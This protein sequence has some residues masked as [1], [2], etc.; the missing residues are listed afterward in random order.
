MSSIRERQAEQTSL[1]GRSR[2]ERL[3]DGI[4]QRQKKY[5]LQQRRRAAAEAASRIVLPD[6]KR[7]RLVLPETPSP[8]TDAAS[9]QKGKAKLRARASQ[10]DAATPSASGPKSVED[11]VATLQR[12]MWKRAKFPKAVKLLQQLWQSH[13]SSSTKR[14]LFAGFLTAASTE[15]CVNASE[16]RT[17]IQTFFRETIEPLLQSERRKRQDLALH[18]DRVRAARTKARQAVLQAQLATVVMPRDSAGGKRHHNGSREDR[19][20]GKQATVAAVAQAAAALVVG[21]EDAKR[22]LEGQ[23][24]QAP[25]GDPR[26]GV[27]STQGD[28]GDAVKAEA[29][30]EV[31][32][33]DEE[34][35]LLEILQ[36]RCKT[37][38]LLFTDDPFQF[39]QQV[40][41]LRRTVDAIAESV[42]AA[43][44]EGEEPEEDEEG[45]DDP[46]P[47]AGRQN[48]PVGADS[49]P[50]PGGPGA[51]FVEAS[52]SLPGDS[53]VS[54]SPVSPA[55]ATDSSHSGLREE[56]ERRGK[57]ACQ[58][59]ASGA[60]GSHTEVSSPKSSA[61][62]GQARET[63]DD[64]PD[65]RAEQQRMP[66]S[67]SEQEEEKGENEMPTPSD[68]ETP[69]CAGEDPDSEDLD[70]EMF[71]SPEVKWPLPL[72]K[73][74]LLNL[75]RCFF[76][77]CLATVFTYRNLSWARASIE[78]L[79][80]H[81]YLH[82][83]I[84]TESDQGQISLWQAQLKVAHKTATNITALGIGEAAHPVQDGRDER[85]STV[86]GSIVWSAKQMGC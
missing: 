82:R 76:I 6:E 28:R 77:D 19:D 70:E 74:E 35:E 47:E 51:K 23:K 52:A 8:S 32:L 26:D 33:S 62:P 9:A 16:G 37:H 20:S 65:N 69:D 73:S 48:S 39:N 14:C 68:P 75:M 10:H 22:R 2:A 1:L 50:L 66:A 12:H 30:D 36:L 86:H 83:S 54:S 13:F 3:L 72:K 71:E 11:A 42:E 44:A 79:F 81:V 18:L 60:T 31:E 17:E 43:A 85:I 55:K 29:Q 34:K 15:T 84:F 67:S 61:T 46:A 45:T 21:L 78:Q 57:E 27:G 63:G 41:E 5:L 25:G 49:A 40:A 58:A 38:L 7:R 80:Q 56:E 4:Y 53:T 64:Q 24:A 59:L